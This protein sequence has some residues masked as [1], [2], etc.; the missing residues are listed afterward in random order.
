M[1]GRWGADCERASNDQPQSGASSVS[2]RYSRLVVKGEPLFPQP[3]P[4]TCRAQ[5]PRARRPAPPGLNHPAPV[6]RTHLAGVLSPPRQSL[7]PLLS[8]RPPAQLSANVRRSAPPVPVVIAR[9]WSWTSYSA[10]SRACCPLVMGLWPQRLRTRHAPPE[11]ILSIVLRQLP[12]L[13]AAGPTCL[14]SQ[15][16]SRKYP[17]E[18]AP[19]LDWQHLTASLSKFLNQTLSAVAHQQSAITTLRLRPR[20][21]LPRRGR[22]QTSGSRSL[23]SLLNR[24]LPSISRAPVMLHL[25]NG[26]N[27]PCSDRGCRT[28]L[29]FRPTA[30]SPFRL[31]RHLLTG[32]P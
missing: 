17:H 15:R 29:S 18:G 13:L 27:Q 30:R 32:Q 31:P 9:G 8:R 22:R 26:R 23:L 12:C 1:R 7:A 4:R 3:H 6:S 5:L 14:S 16:C 11:P 10:S 25:G 2:A 20:L 19:E 24:L 21:S 28:I